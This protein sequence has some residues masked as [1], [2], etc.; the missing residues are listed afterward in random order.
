MQRDLRAFCETSRAY[1]TARTMAGPDAILQSWAR[2]AA[3]EVA[4][5][6]GVVLS[7]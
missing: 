2:L 1:V 4:P 6:E 5:R 7:F 3:G